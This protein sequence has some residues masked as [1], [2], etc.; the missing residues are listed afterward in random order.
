MEQNLQEI[1]VSK[2]VG[3][4]F[5]IYRAI[6][7]TNTETEEDALFAQILIEFN[8]RA[9]EATLEVG[10]KERA[11]PMANI[12]L[13]Q[14]IEVGSEGLFKLRVETAG[15]VPEIENNLKGFIEHVQDGINKWGEETFGGVVTINDK[16]INPE[17]ISWVV[18]KKEK[19]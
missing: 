7:A 11:I 15:G 4:L 1:R 9:L 3:M 19:K 17:G 10:L 14:S 12:S 6:F 13:W 18:D 8:R 16:D 2:L 5:E